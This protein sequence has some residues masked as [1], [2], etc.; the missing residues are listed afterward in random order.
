MGTTTTGVMA[1]PDSLSDEERIKGL[2]R[3]TASPRWLREALALIAR[4]AADIPPN[5]DKTRTMPAMIY[6]H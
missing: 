6:R 2:A 3:T 1:T 4:E 5:E